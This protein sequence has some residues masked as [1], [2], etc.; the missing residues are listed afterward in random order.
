MHNCHRYTNFQERYDYYF[1]NLLDNL[2]K[3]NKVLS[4]GFKIYQHSLN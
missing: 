1:N 2:S 4:Q 3:E